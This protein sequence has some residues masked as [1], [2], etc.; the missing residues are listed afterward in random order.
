MKLKY[1]V[2]AGAALGA[3]MVLAGPA[4]AA[5]A[6]Y[7]NLNAATSGFDPADPA[8]FGPLADSFTTGSTSVNI[9]DVKL[10]LQGDPQGSTV[11][12][13]LL[14]DNATSPGAIIATSGAVFDGFL[15]AP[16]P[17]DFSLS[18]SL[19]ANTRYWVEL[20]T[21]DNAL[22][23]WDWSLDTSGPG[24]ANEYLSNQN[25]VFAN[26]NNGPYQMQLLPA[27]AVPEPMTWAMLTLG[28]FGAGA[29]LRGR[30]KAALA[31]A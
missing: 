3:T 13:N 26:I 29:A 19:A 25:G 11:V 6:L 22:V 28:M 31:T 5:G 10:L 8:V 15:G 16:A 17:E 27:G 23:S 24:V 14:S 12:V 18:A 2:L 9:S 4:S 7:D 30:R 20:T 21:P 1:M